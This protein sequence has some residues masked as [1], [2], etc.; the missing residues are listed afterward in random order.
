MQSKERRS[1]WMQLQKNY[2]N[3]SKTQLRKKSP[4]VYA[5]LYRNDRNWLNLNSPEKL[6]AEPINNRVDW[7]ARDQEVL[8]RVQN[9]ANEFR[10]SGDKP[11]RVTVKSLGDCIVERTLL[12]MHLNKLPETKG[13]IDQVWE[14]KREFRLRRVEHAIEVMKEAGEIIKTWRVLRKAGIKSEFYDEV[15]DVI[16]S[17]IKKVTFT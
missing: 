6:K 9:V 15:N 16:Q 4:A 2:P 5:F 10:N 12:E 8:K 3:L 14:S 1:Q 17:H 7:P 11:I 13:S